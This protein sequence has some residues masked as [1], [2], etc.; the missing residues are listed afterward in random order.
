MLVIGGGKNKPIC[1]K[2]ISILNTIT[3]PQKI[4]PDTNTHSQNANAYNLS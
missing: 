1:E 4:I 2:L 3:S